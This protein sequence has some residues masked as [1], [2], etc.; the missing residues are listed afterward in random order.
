MITKGG[1]LVS[2]TTCFNIGRN[3]FSSVF[4]LVSVLQN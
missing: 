4:D 3:D 2:W 1:P